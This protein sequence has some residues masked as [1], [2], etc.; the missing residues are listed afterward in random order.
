MGYYDAMMDMMEA[1][2]DQPEVAELFESMGGPDFLA[3][4]HGHGDMYDQLSDYDSDDDAEP[5]AENAAGPSHERQ[6]GVASRAAA[7]QDADIRA[8]AGSGPVRPAAYDSRRSRLM[9]MSPAD[10][11]CACLRRSRTIARLA[12]WY[13]MDR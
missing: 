5:S 12:A 7:G 3:Q 2:Y 10:V 11:L 1:S 4:A 8:P 13:T 9:L 6:R